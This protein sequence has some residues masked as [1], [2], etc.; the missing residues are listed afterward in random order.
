MSTLVKGINPLVNYVPVKQASGASENLSGSFTD[1]FGRASGQPDVQGMMFANEKT[2]KGSQ[3]KVDHVDK[4]GLDSNK[5]PAK[6]EKKDVI[7]DKNI[8]SVEDAAQKA[9]TSLARDVAQ[10]LGV[11][12][13]EV[14]KAMEVLGLTMADLLNP[15]NMM[16]LVLTLENADML[17][18]MTDEGLYASLTNLLGKAEEALVALQEENGLT[19][20][21]L[22]AILE[23]ISAKVKLKEEAGSKVTGEQVPQEV[24]DEEQAHTVTLERDGEVVEIGIKANG[25]SKEESPELITKKAEVPEAEKDNAESR[26]EHSSKNDSSSQGSNTYGNVLLEQLT[27]RGSVPQAN[28]AFE[29]TMTGNTQDIMN[30]IMD[31]MKIQIKTDLTQMQIQL[32]PASLGTVNINITA[33]DGVI[34]AQFLTQ[35]EAVKAAI[36]SQLVQLKN[37]FEEQGVKVQAVEVAVES[38]GFERSLNGEG[39]G[40]EQSKGGAKKNARKINLNELSPEEETLLDEEAQIAVAMMAADGSTVDYTA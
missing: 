20:E 33:K 12:M 21:E 36:E 3:V 25:S 7:T 31:Y 40:K 6:T 15:D 27:N 1:I 28:V 4:K 26:K 9:G 5:N 29:S 11:S 22:A 34:T 23:Q 19:P 35:N 38:H 32:H 37:S 16:Q 39:N 8:K 30:Q 17:T 10:E 24:P 2:A 13:E 14:E 18:V